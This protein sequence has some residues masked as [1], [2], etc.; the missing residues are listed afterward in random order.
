VL[1]PLQSKR[2]KNGVIE[3]TYAVTV[4]SKVGEDDGH[5]PFHPEDII[6]RSLDGLRCPN[7]N[8]RVL[9]IDMIC[10]ERI[11]VRQPNVFF[12]SSTKNTKDGHV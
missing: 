1:H 9:E 5:E 8:L 4:L 10:C 7:A 3:N 11:D 2:S 6:V 12:F